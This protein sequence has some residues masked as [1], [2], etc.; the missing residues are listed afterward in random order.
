[1]TREWQV[2]KDGDM[3]DGNVLEQICQKEKEQK[4]TLFSRE[5]ERKTKRKN[6]ENKL[7][8]EIRS[9]ELEN[10]TGKVREGEVIKRHYVR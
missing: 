6:I 10:D 7:H 3:S 2:I 1:M 9:I 4:L 8:N 5:K